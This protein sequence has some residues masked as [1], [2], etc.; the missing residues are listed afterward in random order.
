MAPLGKKS[1]NKQAKEKENIKK[2]MEKKKI[3][4]FQLQENAKRS[5]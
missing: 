2:N 4:F 3:I 5:M 1:K